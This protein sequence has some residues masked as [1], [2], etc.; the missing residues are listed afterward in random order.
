MSESGSRVAR[1]IVDAPEAAFPDDVP[2]SPA[3]AAGDFVFTSPMGATDW[4]TGLAPAA[5]ADADLLL[6]KRRG[7]VT[8]GL[9]NLLGHLSACHVPGGA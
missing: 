7:D 9:A 4:A 3:V 8:Q 1:R 5:R 2:A 6:G